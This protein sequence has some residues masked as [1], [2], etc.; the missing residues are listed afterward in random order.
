MWLSRKSGV[1]RHILNV[2]GENSNLVSFIDH[3]A[4]RK[5]GFYFPSPRPTYGKNSSTATSTVTVMDTFKNEFWKERNE[6]ELTFVDKYKPQSNTA[7]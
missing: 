5:L 7:L 3:M 1:M 2:H 6:E 4:G